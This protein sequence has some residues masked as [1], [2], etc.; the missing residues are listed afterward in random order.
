MKD[1]WCGKLTL[2]NGRTISGGAARN[3]RIAQVG[4]MEAIIFK[5]GQG[6]FEAASQ[7]FGEMNTEQPSNVYYLPQRAK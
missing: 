3:R 6:V 7:V 1:K 5:V 2:A 4:G